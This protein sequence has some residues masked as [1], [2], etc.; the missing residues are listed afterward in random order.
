MFLR[1]G[2]RNGKHVVLEELQIVRDGYDSEEHITDDPLFLHGGPK[3]TILTVSLCY[4]QSTLNRFCS[5]TSA[6]SQV[7]LRGRFGT[8]TS[9]LCENLILP[10]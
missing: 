4:L 9:N 2:Y 3:N 1:K 8:I 7:I 5:R 6:R 10:Y